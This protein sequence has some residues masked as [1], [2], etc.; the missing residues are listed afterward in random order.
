MFYNISKQILFL[1]RKSAPSL[2]FYLS[3]SCIWLD[4]H[5][6]RMFH[7][8]CIMHLIAMAEFGSDLLFAM[9]TCNHA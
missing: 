9:F 8:A 1:T 2:I 4:A 6:P 7:T 3:Y 5:N